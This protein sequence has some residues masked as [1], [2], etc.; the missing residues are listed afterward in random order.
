[1]K[2]IAKYAGLMLVYLGVILLTVF[3]FTG[4]SNH[5]ICNLLG[6]F[7]IVAGIIGYILA[8]RKQSKY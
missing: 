4:L 7:L 8:Q 3:Y 2:K 5:N 6:F 1:M